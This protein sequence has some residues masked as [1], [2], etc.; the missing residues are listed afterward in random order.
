MYNHTEYHT[1]EQTWKQ[2]IVE[3]E[4]KKTWMHLF[5]NKINWNVI[6]CKL[7]CLEIVLSAK[8]VV[9]LVSGMRKKKKRNKFGTLAGPLRSQHN[10]IFCLPGSERGLNKYVMKKKN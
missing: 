8:S 6:I 10:L 2:N 3:I 5:A 7:R 9:G 1:R 4:F